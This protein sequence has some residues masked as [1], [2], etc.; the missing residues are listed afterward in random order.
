[1]CIQKATAIQDVIETKKILFIEF[2]S[3]NFNITTDPMIA[4]SA[5]DEMDKLM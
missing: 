4:Y 3:C 2:Y 1:M 5:H